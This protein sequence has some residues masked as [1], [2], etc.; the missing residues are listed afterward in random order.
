MCFTL[1]W[2]SYGTS[3][4]RQIFES[5]NG[6]ISQ[7]TCN[8]VELAGIFPAVK[9][10][11]PEGHIKTHTPH[12]EKCALLGHY[13][14]MRGNFLPTS[15]DNL[16]VPSSGFR[17]RL[18]GC[19]ETSVRNYPYSSRNNLE[20]RSSLIYLNCTLACSLVDLHSA[21]WCTTKTNVSATVRLIFVPSSAKLQLF[22]QCKL[23]FT[24]PAVSIG[25]ALETKLSN[26]NDH[27]S[28]V[29]SC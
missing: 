20:E 19:P 25:W 27:V 13:S 5:C 6:I 14:T 1:K 15:R 23:P 2:R 7:K 26:T 29:T 22:W 8:H 4:S 21:E 11:K 24:D 12:F 10:T 9:H 28:C 3:K 18:V 17:M 16:S